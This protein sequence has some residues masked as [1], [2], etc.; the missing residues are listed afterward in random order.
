MSTYVAIFLASLLDP[1][2]FFFAVLLAWPVRR[3]PTK[4]VLGL[5]LG[6]AME[7]I[8][9]GLYVVKEFGDR[10]L[11]NWLVCTLHVFIVSA[12]FAMPRLTQRSE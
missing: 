11:L 7:A 6:L 2:K 3:W 8:G 12:V 1:L 4:L 10:L 5:L 9:M